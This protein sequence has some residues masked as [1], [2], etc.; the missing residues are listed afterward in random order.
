VFLAK[1]VGTTLVM[2]A[3]GLGLYWRGAR[4]KSSAKL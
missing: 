1:V 4:A 3:V 2:V